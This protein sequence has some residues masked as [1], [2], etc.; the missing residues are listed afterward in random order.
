MAPTT[1]S[2][3]RHLIRTLNYFV[4]T[5]ASDELEDDQLSILDLE[6][7]I[8]TGEITSRQRDFKTREVKCVVAGSALD[9]SRA[10]AVIKIGFSGRLVVVTVYRC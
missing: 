8:L 5:H 1:I 2:Q 7:I 10:E 6:N 9:G 3:F 4:S